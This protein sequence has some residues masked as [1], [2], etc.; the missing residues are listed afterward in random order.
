MHRLTADESALNVVSFTESLH[1][2]AAQKDISCT[3][4]QHS[5]PAPPP[6]SVLS[7]PSTFATRDAV[8][9]HHASFMRN[10]DNPV[11]LVDFGDSKIVRAK[12]GSRTL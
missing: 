12:F 11:K 4:F 8:E 3:R 1:P 2:R 6:R 9:Q 10:I 5:Q 7:R